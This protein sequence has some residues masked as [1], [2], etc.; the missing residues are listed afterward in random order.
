MSNLNEKYNVN[1]HTIMIY[2]LFLLVL[3]IIVYL[4]LKNTNKDGFDSESSNESIDSKSITTEKTLPQATIGIVT[5]IESGLKEINDEVMK[6]KIVNSLTDTNKLLNKY[7]NLDA[8]IVIGDNGTVCAQWG[9]YNNNQ[10]SNRGN[11]CTVIDD[12]KIRKCLKSDESLDTCNIY[13]SDG[14]VDKNNKI[15]VTNIYN[16]AKNN[17]LSKLNIVKNEISD[18]SKNIDLYLNDLITQKNLETQQIYFVDYNTANL[19]DKQ[20]L[21][22][23]S[24]NEYEKSENDVNI[25]QLKFSDFL[26]NDR[27]ADN[28]RNIYYK[29][30]I[31]MCITIIIFGI[32]NFL[33]SNIL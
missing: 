6:N 16:I 33:F 13:Y 20:K 25:N 3:G 11:R 10:Y 8:P 18:K 26:E 29:I 19:E 22:D 14:V 28:K 30:L 9:S 4:Y 23:I 15:D 17:M 31:G 27:N 5:D 12:S 7:A 21:L 24:K 1:E 2:I 32:L